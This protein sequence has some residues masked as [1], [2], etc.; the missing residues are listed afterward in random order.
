M[1]NRKYPE[2]LLWGVVLLWG[3]NYTVGKWGMLSFD[4]L[5]FTVLRFLGATPLLFLLLYILEKDIR[6]AR[7]DLRELAF[8]GLCGVAAYQTLFTATVK[9]ASATNAALL[10]AMSPVFTAL[11]SWLTGQERLGRNGKLGSLL[12]FIGVLLIILFG[13]HQL[14]TG[15]SAWFG[16]LV[17]IMASAMWGLY[18]VLSRRMFQKYSGLKTTTYAALFGT[19]FLLAIGLPGLT[20]IA[21]SSIQAKAWGSLGYAIGPVTAYGLVVW[22]QGISKIG[23]NRVMAYMYSIPVV[24]AITAATVLGER[25]EILQGVGA[26]IIFLGITLI[27][28]D[29]HNLVLKPQ[30]TIGKLGVH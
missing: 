20:T 29:K 7:T 21:W 17:G 6:V 15:E 22:N 16:N 10:I 9:Y 27:R 30:E 24:A 23:A 19:V 18:P 5:S 13:T 3:A 11:F 8:L 12:A 25:I 28:Q 1:P 2:L 4:P 14:A 26:L